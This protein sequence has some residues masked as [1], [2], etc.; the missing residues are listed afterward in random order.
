MSRVAFGPRQM[1]AHVSLTNMAAAS[2]A[3][4]KLLEAPRPRILPLSTTSKSSGGVSSSQV[5]LSFRGD[6]FQGGV[7]VDG[8]VP[9]TLAIASGEEE[10]LAM[11]DWKRLTALTHANEQARAAASEA[12]VRAY[13][14]EPRTGTKQPRE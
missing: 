5:E 11:R 8:E 1:A 14:M 7:G 13:W 12:E 4:A 6:S 10:E 9:S 3:D 2:E